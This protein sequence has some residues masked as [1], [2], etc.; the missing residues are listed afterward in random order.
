MVY[1]SAIP[2]KFIEVRVFVHAT[3]DI[4]KVNEAIKHIFPPD[5]ENE[6][7]PKKTSLKGHYGNPIK[8][9]EIK[10]SGED[11]TKS[12]FDYLFSKLSSTDKENIIKEIN[13]CNEK[14]SLYL[15][16]DKQAAHC[17]NLKLCR[18]DPI[19]VRIRFKQRNINHILKL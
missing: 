19:H 11:V 14:G 10:I 4:T 6:I 3:E 5:I 7:I 9:L 8:L 2:I 15:R 18:E 17:G 1:L 12:F 16:F 13:F